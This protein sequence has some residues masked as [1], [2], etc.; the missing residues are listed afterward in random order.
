MIT[1]FNSSKYLKRL[2]SVTRM[3]GF[4]VTSSS[5]HVIA[6]ALETTRSAAAY[7][8]SIERKNLV[9]LKIMSDD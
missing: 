2:R 8:I 6:P 5:E 4:P 7:A 9:K 3:A 1:T